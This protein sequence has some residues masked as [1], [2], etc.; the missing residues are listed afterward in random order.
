MT[1]EIAPLPELAT[2]TPE[3]AAQPE[4]E[5]ETPSSDIEEVVLPKDVGEEE[6][7]LEPV[8]E[9]EY[10]TVE[11]N[12]KTFQVPKELEGEFFMQ[13]DYTKKTQTVA[14]RAKAL[15]ERSKVSHP[16]LL[17]I[18]SSQRQTGRP[19]YRMTPTALSSIVCGMRP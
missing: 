7:N 10:V 18:R 4:V 15:D 16:S 17:N 3:V 5:T 19:I 1:D 8:P 13:A 6:E 2:A 11:R 14:E 12:G 9:L